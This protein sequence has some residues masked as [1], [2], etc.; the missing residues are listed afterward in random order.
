M[1][2]R[3]LGSKAQGRVLASLL[4]SISLGGRWSLVVPVGFGLNVEIARFCSLC[5][6]MEWHKNDRSFEWLVGQ[7]E[8]KWVA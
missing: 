8:F 7:A 5:L 1:K 3:G 6:I 4:S 2:D